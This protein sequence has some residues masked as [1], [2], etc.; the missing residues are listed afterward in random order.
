MSTKLYI[1]ERILNAEGRKEKSAK[2]GA[3]K[4]ACAGY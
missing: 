1:T 4:E 3:K 2:R